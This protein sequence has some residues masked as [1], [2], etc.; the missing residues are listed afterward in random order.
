[1]MYLV[2]DT[3]DRC[4]S[5]VVRQVIWT[6]RGCTGISMMA[7]SI[8]PSH[9]VARAYGGHFLT[10]VYSP[11]RRSLSTRTV[12]RRR[13]SPSAVPPRASAYPSKVA[14]IRPRYIYL[15]EV[16]A[17]DV[18]RV[19]T[20][21]QSIADEPTQHIA[22]AQ[23]SH[24]AALRNTLDDPMLSLR[25]PVFSGRDLPP[26]RVSMPLAKEEQPKLSMPQVKPPAKSAVPWM[27]EQRNLH[28]I[29]QA[30]PRDIE[31]ID[32]F[33][34]LISHIVRKKANR[35]SRFGESVRWWLLH[36]GRLE[37][38][39]WIGVTIILIFCTSLLLIFF[40]ARLGYITFGA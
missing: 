8:Y 18:T 6:A 3:V 26:A 30:R 5:C 21:P 14:H 34:P 2:T 23:R 15:N 12:P 32:T 25:Q 27:K 36:P 1:M 9:R 13:Q 28:A 17:I 33:P 31:E 10:S 39:L 19:P 37:L 40:A 20:A 4:I 38:L 22:V 16:P 35:L 7:K 11:G 29:I 24:T